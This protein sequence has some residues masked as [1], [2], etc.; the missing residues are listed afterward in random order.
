MRK[1]TED[2]IALSIVLLSLHDT[3]TELIRKAFK[4]DSCDL[5]LRFGDR[6]VIVRDVNDKGNK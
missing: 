3:P 6:E 5:H 1:L 4:A 2:E